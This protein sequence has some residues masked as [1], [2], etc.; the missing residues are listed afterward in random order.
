M[1]HNMEV[2]DGVTSF[3]RAD[4]EAP[5]W[6]A[7]YDG[8]G[9][10]QVF[11]KGTDWSQVASLANLNH[12][13]RLHEMVTVMDDN[14][15]MVDEEGSKFY[16]PARTWSSGPKDGQTELIGARAFTER[17][18]LVQV[19]DMAEIAKCIETIMPGAHVAT[20]GG[21]RN[22]NRAFITVR[23][24]QVKVDVN[25]YEDV[26][27]LYLSILNSWDASSPFAIINGSFRTVC[28][29]TYSGNLAKALA[30]MKTEKGN[31]RGNFI[32]GKAVLLKHV[33]NMGDKLEAAKVAISEEMGWADAYQTYAQELA[34]TKM[35]VQQFKKMVKAL[36]P[37]PKETG[38]LRTDAMNTN[39]YERKLDVL[40]DE[41]T[42][43]VKERGGST[44]WGALNSFTAFTTH[45]SVAK[46][47]K[48]SPGVELESRVFGD[49]ITAGQGRSLIDQ[50]SDYLKDFSLA[51]V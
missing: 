20:A 3:A 44:A 51:K 45:Y 28:D 32:S 36:V 21:L 31:R 5:P 1:A 34:R 49:T 25:D 47:T 24:G 29:N 33:G 12:E 13:V 19:K 2:I 17:Y 48:L 50:V 8:L 43:E 39:N 6:W 11:V 26:T 41:W 37:E 27:N 9:E 16:R 42:R 46:G 22:G 14:K 40:T 38:S 18:S 30:A 10:G 7:N 35:T 4:T 23:L 15:T